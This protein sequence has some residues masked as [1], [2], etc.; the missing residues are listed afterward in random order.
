MAFKIHVSDIWAL[1]HLCVRK[2]Y[3][4]FDYIENLISK[5]TKV[6]LSNNIWMFC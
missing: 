2:L 5:T 4:G 3:I 1:A 6:S